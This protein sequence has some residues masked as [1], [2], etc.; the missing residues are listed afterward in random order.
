MLLSAM[1]YA[2]GYL[3]GLAAFLLMAWKRRLLTWG[4]VSLLGVGLVGGLASA[5]L[6]QWLVS[7]DVGKTV[8][9]GIAGGYLCVVLYKRYLGIRRPL[10]DLFAVAISA[11]EAVGRWGCF[12]AGCC[13]GRPSDAPWAVWQHEAYRHPGQAYLSLANLA[14]LIILLVLERK[15]PPE[16]T[17][18]YSQGMLYCGSRFCIEFYRDT[19]ILISGLSLAQWACAAGFVFFAIKMHRLMETIRRPYEAMS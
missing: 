6:V 9:G 8:L 17:L 14:I 5:N 18:F 4:V 19:P 1:L 3:T 12:A 10:G 11:G 2:A 16:N 13:Y 15:H 7:G